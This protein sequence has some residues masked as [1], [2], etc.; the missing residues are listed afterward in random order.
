MQKARYRETGKMGKRESEDRLDKLLRFPTARTP[1]GAAGGGKGGGLF[2]PSVVWILNRAIYPVHG[3]GT[4]QGLQHPVERV[5]FEQIAFLDV[6]GERRIAAV[7][8]ELFQLH[9]MDAPVFGGIH[10]AAL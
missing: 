7:A 4:A 8:T 3:T 2:M 10:S 6:G 5:V 9:R 1:T